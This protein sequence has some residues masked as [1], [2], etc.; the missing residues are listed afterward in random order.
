MCCTPIDCGSAAAAP[1]VLLVAATGAA[2]AH[3]GGD[4]HSYSAFRTPP[5]NIA[6]AIESDGPDADLFWATV[7]G[8]GLTGIVVRAR[9]RMKHTE[10]AYF[11]LTRLIT[12]PPRP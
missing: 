5:S 8:M 3:P 4:Q 1:V 11:R 2:Q 9:I 12:H 6:C 10:T 7:G